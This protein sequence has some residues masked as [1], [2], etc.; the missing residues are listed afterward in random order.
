MEIEQHII[1]TLLLVESDLKWDHKCFHCKS[2]SGAFRRV[3]NVGV[4]D[5]ARWSD[6][7]EG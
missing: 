5:K 6:E 4:I 1:H 2:L 7:H 3:E